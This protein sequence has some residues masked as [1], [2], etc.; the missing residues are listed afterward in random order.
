MLLIY[1]FV[2]SV[3]NGSATD[4]HTA[5]YRQLIKTRRSLAYNLKDKTQEERGVEREEG[6]EKATSGPSS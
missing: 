4:S 1:L 5:V 3:P 2:T 6:G